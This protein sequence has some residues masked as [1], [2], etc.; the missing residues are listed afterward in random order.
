LKIPSLFSKKN[1]SI[2]DLR[3]QRTTVAE[4]LATAETT[5]KDKRTAC[6][7]VAAGL[8]PG[9]L[10][11]IEAEAR[12]AEDRV[13]SLRVA[14]EKL[15]ARI[16]AAQAEQAQVKLDADRKAA[17]SYCLDLAKRAQEQHQEHERWLLGAHAS[18]MG[19]YS[20]AIGRG[21]VDF[22]DVHN[23]ARVLLN[24]LA[25]VARQF[26]D[27][28]EVISSGRDDDHMRRVLRHVSAQTRAD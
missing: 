6:S 10:N 2:D 11:T 8:A 5:A 20:N 3:R 27:Y 17:A 14:L 1:V 7:D 26:T 15:D 13:T 23:G 21:D 12:A 19:E 16:A 28:A 25:T 9:S 24:D 22:R 4:Q 18:L